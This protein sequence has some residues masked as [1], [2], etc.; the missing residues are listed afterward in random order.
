[1]V[2]L[3]LTEN[4]VCFSVI[5]AEALQNS[6]AC[7]CFG[8]LLY[9]RQ[10]MLTMAEDGEAGLFSKLENIKEIRYLSSSQNHIKSRNVE[11]C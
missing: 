5:N 1:M 2:S 10:K 3:C 4:V 6:P 11:T 8:N 7:F 9:R